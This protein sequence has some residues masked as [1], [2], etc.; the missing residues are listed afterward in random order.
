M[1]EQQR[2]M[3]EEILFSEKKPLSF[4]QKL[5]FGKFDASLVFPYPKMSPEEV[6]PFNTLYAK[7]KEF[8]D[9]NIDAAAIDRNADIPPFVL[10][11]LANLGVLGMTVP[12]EF[13]G[14]GMSQQA[15]CKVTEFHCRPLWIDRV[16]HQCSS[17][18]RFEVASS[19]WNR[20]STRSMV[21]TFGTRRATCGFFSDRAKCR[22]RCCWY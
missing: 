6:I 16:D 8:A 5:F 12:K 15:Y 7:V 4:A 21:G 1:D 20:V 18:H 2:R 14:L 10:S 3:A 11:G 13:G 22:F 19:V 17:E 9:K